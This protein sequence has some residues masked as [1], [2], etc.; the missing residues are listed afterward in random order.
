MTQRVRL[1]RLHLRAVPVRFSVRG[2][3]T[4]S[5]ELTLGRR[6]IQVG[7]DPA[8]KKRTCLARVS[9]PYRCGVIWGSANSRGWLWRNYGRAAGWGV[10]SICG[11]TPGRL[12]VAT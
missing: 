3:R 10:G 5:A 12:G 1:C 2:G 8:E 6:L 4:A 7:G 9:D 11:L